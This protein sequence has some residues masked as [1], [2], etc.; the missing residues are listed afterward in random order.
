MSNYK[1]R[2]KEIL[3]KEKITKEDSE[4]LYK[5]LDYLYSKVET[6]LAKGSIETIVSTF[7]SVVSIPVTI[8]APEVGIPMFIL[9]VICDSAA[10]NGLQKVK[11]EKGHTYKRIEEYCAIVNKL[12]ENGYEA[13]NDKMKELLDHVLENEF[14]KKLLHHDAENETTVMEEIKYTIKHSKPYKQAQEAFDKYF[15]ENK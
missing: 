5:R 9:S 4:I 8:A 15:E 13:S 11:E 1:N 7:S 6:K 14:L 3:T 2:A 12:N 10:I